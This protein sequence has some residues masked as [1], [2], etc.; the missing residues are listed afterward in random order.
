M[1][2]LDDMDLRNTDYR[3]VLRHQPSLKEER[4]TRKLQAKRAR[5][6]ER[7]QRQTGKKVRIE[8]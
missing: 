8:E 3:R 2:F 6:E 4:R 5:L 7:L 1:G